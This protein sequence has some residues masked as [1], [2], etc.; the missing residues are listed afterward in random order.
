MYA[1]IIG[2]E[3][4]GQLEEK[5]EQVQMNAEISGPPSEVGFVK[6]AEHYERVP[7]HVLRKR[8]TVN[9]LG[10]VDFDA[11][12]PK[13]MVKP[14]RFWYNV[15]CRL[16][17]AESDYLQETNEYITMCAECSREKS[18]GR[19]YDNIE[20]NISHCPNCAANWCRKYSS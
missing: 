20:V 8:K 14:D 5:L 13:P 12:T 16:I 7:S 9:P 10:F 17:N 1:C 2:D 6:P 4:I 19:R 18:E 3:T 15:G 11:V